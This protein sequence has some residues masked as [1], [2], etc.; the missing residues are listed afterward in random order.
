VAAAVVSAA[1]LGAGAL[2]LVQADDDGPDTAR[3]SEPDA[4]AAAAYAVAARART[5]VPFALAASS[6]PDLDGLVTGAG[7]GFLDADE[8]PALRRGRTYQLWA[9]ADGEAVPVA[10]LGRD[11]GVVRFAV[12]EGATSVAVTEED[13]P[14]ASE[15]ASSLV[16]EGDLEG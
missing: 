15:P 1:A 6:G 10:L 16:A 8:L 4:A 7:D 3:A 11:P 14:G 13:D 5:S 2:G 12:P 9:D